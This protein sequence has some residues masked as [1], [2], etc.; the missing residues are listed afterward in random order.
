MIWIFCLPLS[1]W[2]QKGWTCCLLCS[3][4]ETKAQWLS[5][6]WIWEWTDLCLLSGFSLLCF[7]CDCSMTPGVESPL[8][9]LYDTPT[10]LVWGITYI[11]W[12]RVSHKHKHTHPAVRVCITLRSIVASGEILGFGSWLKKKCMLG[13]GLNQQHS[14]HMKKDHHAAITGFSKIFFCLKHVDRAT[15]N[16]SLKDTLYFRIII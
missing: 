5:F 10:S 3:R 8:K 12:Q 4:Y 13:Q 16:L 1:G 6:S 2:T 14:H 15:F 11:I 7:G 9:P